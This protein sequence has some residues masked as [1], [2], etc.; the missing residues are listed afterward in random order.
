MITADHNL[1]WNSSDPIVGTN[2]IIGE[3]MFWD[4]HLLMHNSPAVD[5]GLAIAQL[6]DDIYGNPR[7]IGAGYDIGAVEM[8][9]LYLPL[10]VK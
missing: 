10:I 2:A 9:F 8:S 1:L 4:D 6:I 3:P 7:P 5:S